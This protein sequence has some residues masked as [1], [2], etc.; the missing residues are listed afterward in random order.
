MHPQDIIPPGL[1]QC[2]CGQVPALAPNTR[3]ERGWVKG[4]P[5]RYLPGHHHRVPRP[6]RRNTLADFELRIDLTGSCHLWTSTRDTRGYG[7]FAYQGK[8]WKAHCLAWV[9]ARGAI[10]DGL[11]ICH[12]C[13]TPLCVRVEHLFLGTREENW[14]DMF[15][16]GRHSRG[17]Q[18]HSAKLTGAM[19]REARRLHAEGWGA[20]RLSRRFGV[21]VHAMQLAIKGK[22]WK[23]V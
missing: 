16:K 14:R 11:Y 6:A 12:H 1:C 17:E 20:V 8:Q 15:D 3:P 4:Q 2:G 22:T 7:V 5:V 10:P 23:H 19:V 9:L 13:D 21:T 18:H